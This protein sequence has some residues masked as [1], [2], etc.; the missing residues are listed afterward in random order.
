MK[1]L[2]ALLR[3]SCNLFEKHEFLHISTEF[4]RNIRHI[5]ALSGELM[6]LEV[7]V[8]QADRERALRF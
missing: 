4:N 2:Y 7:V 5:H 1:L 3:S 8:E 6:A